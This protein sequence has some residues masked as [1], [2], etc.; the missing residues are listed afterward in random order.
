MKYLYPKSLVV[1]L[2]I[3]W[4]FPV[5]SQLETNSEALRQIA[6]EQEKEWKQKAKRVKQFARLHDVEI[7]QEYP[8]GTV[9]ELIDVIDGQPIYY[10]TDN[11]GAAITT[12]A[13]ELWQGGN[14]G[15]VIE[16]EG[17]SKV[18]IWD[19]GAVRRTHQE[20][21][22]TGVQRVTQGDNATSAITHA[23]HVAGTIVAGGVNAN[24]KGMAHKA[25]L[26]AYDWNSAEGEMSAAA[27]AGMEISNHSWGMI[28]GWDY[29]QNT[30]NWQWHGDANVAP[31]EDY[32]F[33]FYNTQARTWDIIAYNAPYFLISVSAGNDRGEGPANA[34]TGDIP[35]K[36]GGIDGY[37]CLGGSS[38]SKN[39]LTVGAVKEVL[40]YTGPA[41]VSMSSFSAWGPTDDGRIKPDIVG[42]GVNV[43][44]S[45]ASSNSSYTSLDGT[46]MSSPNVV[47]SMVL[48][49]QLYQQTHNNQPMRSSTL[50]GLVIH[51][52]DEAGAHP[53]PDYR[54]GWGLMN[55]EKAAQIILEDGEMQNVIDEIILENNGTYSREVT[56]SGGRPFRVTI[57]WTDRNGNIPPPSLNPRTPVIV[58]DLDL[59]ILDESLNIYYPYKLDPE[60]PDAPA[61]TN[62]KNYVDN[63]EMI[64]IDNPEPGTYTIFVDH[65]GTL[66][67]NQVFS[68]IISG[69]D[70]FSDIPECSNGLIDPESGAAGAFLNHKVTWA[71][72]S[73][74]T[75]YDIYFGT[76]G[77]G[78]QTPTN[79]LNGDYQTENFFRLDLQPSTTY[80]LQ[81]KPRNSY[82]VNDCE[83][84]YSF[85]TMGTINDFPFLTNVE[86][87]AP[88]AFPT[89]WSSLDFSSLE[90][91][92]TSLI[93]YNSSKSFAC[94]TQTGTAT[95]LNNWLISPPIQVSSEN[96]YY[97][98]WVY[99]CF[100]PTYPESLR[101]LWGFAAA[102]TNSFSNLL[103][104]NTAFNSPNW[105]TGH[106]LIVPDSDE[107]I[108]IA[109]HANTDNGMGQFIDDILLEDWGPVG[110]ADA[111]EKQVR[112]SYHQGQFIVQSTVDLRGTQFSV[113]NAAGQ[114]IFNET[115]QDQASY[116]K[117]LKLSTGVY[118]VNIKGNEY[119]KTSKLLIQ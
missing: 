25:E 57:C 50:K 65:A 6:K 100:F 74:A 83:T 113:T 49:Q 68:L 23:T 118:I 63:V 79:I 85:T 17:Y 22:N 32:L 75:G 46:S 62:S 21:N 115:I 80:Y 77:G 1:L 31:L 45:T 110:I 55:T 108:F 112:L 61:T 28:R 99:R 39:I 81:V 111:F 2:V 16:G 95:S 92:T 9:V 44:S 64:H 13:N 48:L 66:S 96:E 59:R 58:H 15:V 5:F 102:D 19:G 91:T 60:N 14:V 106:K 101:V 98:S 114:T 8:D 109:F 41:S 54:F 12:R 4:A 72:A 107:F 51:S 86:D 30:G 3:L 117:S 47:G 20:F 52:A 70:E 7:R 82:G 37:D 88:P 53:G 73:F 119:E 97:L 116:S 24:A 93:G 34:G 43:Y 27:N 94:Y 71:P 87:V 18:G 26:K 90:W 35:E 104:E 40:N 103:F 69:I 38:N 89:G 11:L 29:N 84:I 105:E 78:T 10:K 36:D 42:K 33:G 56:V 67:P 76:D